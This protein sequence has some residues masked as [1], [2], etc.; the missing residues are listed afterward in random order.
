MNRATCWDCHHPRTNRKPWT[1]RSECQECVQDFAERHRHETG[2]NVEL[3]IITI[4]NVRTRLSLPAV[5]RI[6]AARIA[7]R[8]GW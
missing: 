2:H 1:V 6:A 3:T 4:E 8:F 7:A 5:A